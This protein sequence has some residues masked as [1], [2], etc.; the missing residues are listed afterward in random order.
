MSKAHLTAIARTTASQPMKRL[1]ELG[2]LYGRAL[3]YG[4][5]RGYDAD[6]FGMDRYDPHYQ[7]VKPEGLFATITCN[8]VLNVIE[9]HEA[10]M[11]V[12][13]DI[14]ARLVP[15]G[16]AYITVRADK[17][18]LIGTTSKGTWQGYITLDLPVVTKRAGFVTYELDE[19]VQLDQ[20]VMTAQTF[21]AA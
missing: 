4:C 12:L 16:K 18:A 7:P 9:S 2:R 17:K 21:Q 3:D 8:Y 13:R 6:E 19:S 14:Q 10:R 1:Y 5:G 20:L 15:G 11:T